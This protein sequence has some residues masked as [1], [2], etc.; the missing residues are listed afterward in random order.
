MSQIVEMR[1]GTCFEVRLH[2]LTKSWN[3]IQILSVAEAMIQDLPQRIAESEVIEAFD[4][5]RAFCVSLPPKNASEKIFESALFSR[6][7]PSGPR[8]FIH[9]DSLHR[10]W[11]MICCGEYDLQKSLWFAPFKFIA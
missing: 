9:C 8:D 5:D 1:E 3:S 6:D 11:K 4:F 2:F 7:L 10:W